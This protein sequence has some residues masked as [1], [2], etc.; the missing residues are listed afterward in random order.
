MSGLRILTAPALDPGAARLEITLPEG[1]TVA[2]IVAAALPA[3]SQA[4]LAHARVAL[5]TPTGSAI[6]PR[7]LWHR[8]RP[9]PG[10]RIV[11]RL[12]PGKDALRTILSI[13]VSIA[14]LALG[15]MFGPA[16]G[17]F[18]GIGKIAGTALVTIGANLLGNL[19]INAL[20]PPVKPDEERPSFSI[21]GWRNR[22]DP[23][24]A[25]PVLLGQI[26]YTP[27][28]AAQSWTE[29]SGDLQY[30]HAL[31]NFGE[32]PIEL[33]DFRIGDTSISEFDE[34][35]IEVRQGHA[36]DDPCSLYPLQI[37]E[38]QIGVELTRPL[39]RNDAGEVTGGAPIETPVVRTTG[40]DA[41]GASVI[42][43]FP[44]GLAWFDDDGDKHHMA[45]YVRVEQR[46]V[47]AEEWTETT[48][49][50]L[51]GRKAEGFYRQHTWTFPERG[52]WQIRLTMLSAETEDTKVL[53]RLV[54]AGL[55][56]IRPEY[57][58]NYHRPLALVAVRA[59][60]TYQLSGAL[61]TFSAMG[62][63]ICLDWDHESETWLTRAT[64]NPASLYRY[65]L[66]C[67]ANPKPAPDAEID[68]A[69]L[70]DWHDFCRLK[71]L[72]YNRVQ[73]RAGT[74][75]REA[76]TE[77]AVAGRASPRHD[78]LRWGVV[79]DRPADLIV[80]HVSPRNS[81]NV[82][83]SRA[84]TEKPHAWIARFQDQGNDYATAE[85][86]IRRP[87]YAG[88]ITL[89]EPL[90]MPGLTDAAIVYREG[91]RRFHEAALRPDLIEVTQDGAV[92]VATRGDAVVIS[93][94]VLSNTQGSARVRAV[95]GTAV[96]LDEA[97]TMAEGV[98]YALRFRVFEG[99]A[100]TVGTSVIRAVATLPGESDLVTLTGNGP[101]PLAG[102]L[103][104][105]G[106]AGSESFKVIVSR[107][108]TTEDQCSILRAVA[109]APEIDTLTDAAEIPDWSSRV[110]AEIDASLLAPPAP[111]FTSVSST[112]VWNP[113]EGREPV[114][115]WEPGEINYFLKPG[116]G[117]VYTASYRIGHRLGTVSDWTEFDLPAASSGGS[118]APY[119]HGYTAQIRAQ[120][121]SFAG[122]AGPWSPPITLVIGAGAA[123]IPAALD[124]ESIN[125]TPLLGGALIQ[126]ATGG[127]GA[128]TRLQIYRSTSDVLDRATDAVG[129]PHPVSPLTS[130]SFALGDTTRS[131]LVTNG[132]FATEA[133]W[134]PGAGWAIAAGV[135][136]HTG[137]ASGAI[138]QGITTETG[139]WYR[140]AVTV[141]DRTAGT[142][143]PQ[144]TGGSTISGTVATTNAEH[145]D[146]LQAVS[147]NDTVGF[148]A[149]ATFDGAIDDAVLYL[150]TAACLSQ[151]IHYVWVEPQNADGSPG[152]AVGPF[153]VTII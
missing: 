123:A 81:W 104:L 150:E 127:D 94:D 79:I 147:G 36:G 27:P 67:P 17:T 31:F 89:T 50:T 108:E 116:A 96:H 29:I 28:F 23:N 34:I 75:L 57:P 129:T 5:V 121:I 98:S 22:L 60:A 69:Q 64:S 133:A 20:I 12:I 48:V 61:D 70:A 44:S 88:D 135:A 86:V 111:R 62:R 152:P 65:V 137:G 115:F 136:T 102:D 92:R 106:E 55:Q 45:I 132:G 53:Q 42:F 10:V 37:L 1:L 39:P 21:S 82:S 11:I 146:R 118:I 100:D 148:L 143:T 68:L 8:V 149:S 130:Y 93:H 110:G 13:V 142:L 95:V 3:A 131:N 153:P 33:S 124:P 38:E 19:L 85:R 9:K 54:W 87:G 35:D 14:A 139:K 84:Y 2:E 114:G 18:L 125:I 119:P 66:Q 113:G 46:L 59:K 26:R 134:V 51:V 105:F 138:T 112:V 49:L 41:S 6:V 80:D 90:E 56:T 144:L 7:A 120:A 126:L 99:D 109:A 141:K 43:A 145:L 76:L 122:V 101:M 72:H 117:L 30:I 58:L 74:T 63:R 151:G 32:G 15:T 16:V 77:I 4:D 128:T 71:G 24:G 140:A 97:V 47:T 103:V 25:V 78:G 107:V 40:S 52:R 83:V 73:D 91:I